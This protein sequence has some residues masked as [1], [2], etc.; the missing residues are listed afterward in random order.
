MTS[1]R[2]GFS[3][4]YIVPVLFITGL[5]TLV[6][7]IYFFVQYQRANKLLQSPHAAMVQE[8]DEIMQIIRPI[9]HIKNDE[10]PTIATV[11]DKTKLVGQP[12]FE[13]TENGDKVL[14][15]KTSN[16]VVLFRPSIKKVIAVSSIPQGEKTTLPTTSQNNTAPLRVTV[17]N[18]S[19]VNGVA[20]KTA[21]AI[22][23]KIENV[24]IVK[25]ETAEK[26][27]YTK[28]QIVYTSPSSQPIASQIAELI[29]GE[30]TTKLPEGESNFD[31]DI[32]VIAIQ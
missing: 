21:E 24:T 7:C 22:L 28:A 12:F 2:L 1:K 8:G 3:Q 27:T 25:E 5:I 19:R 23:Q 31:A 20:K 30:I 18:G 4:F 26:K 29:N 32:V 6:L 9:I 11:A 14:I 13:R 17:L 16:T 10:K 15:F